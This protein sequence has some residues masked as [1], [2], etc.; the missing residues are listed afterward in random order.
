MKG[1]FMDCRNSDSNANGLVTCHGKMPKM[2]GNGA[3]E[4]ATMYCGYRK[5]V[6]GCNDTDVVVGRN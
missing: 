6:D 3:Y 2:N 5:G 1:S 4:N